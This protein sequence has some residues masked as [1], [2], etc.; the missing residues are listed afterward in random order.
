MQLELCR[1]SLD[2]FVTENK[3]ISEPMVWSILLDLLLALKSLHDKN[4]IHLDIKLENVLI[5]DGNVCKLGDFGL[6]IDLNRKNLHLATEGDSRYVAP[7]VLNGE[8][9]KAADIFSLGI[10]VLELACNLELP[11]NGPLWQNLRHGI[12]PY[13]FNNCKS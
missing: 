9:T 10:A 6:V 1:C 2:A 12:F 13:E 4:L 8:F 7:E 11:S 3:L 5:S